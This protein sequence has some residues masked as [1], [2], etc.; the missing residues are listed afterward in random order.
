MEKNRCRPSFHIKP[1]NRL[2]IREKFRKKE[3]R[4]KKKK[5]KILFEVNVEF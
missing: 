3:K 2:I 4:E 5:K 1:K